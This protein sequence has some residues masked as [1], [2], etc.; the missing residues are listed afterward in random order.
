IAH[1]A[2]I[3]NLALVP[4]PLILRDDNNKTGLFLQVGI[5]VINR[6]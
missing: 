3:A 6:L 2:R 1:I 4:H 5:K